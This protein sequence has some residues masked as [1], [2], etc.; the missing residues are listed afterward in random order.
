MYTEKDLA[1]IS[2]IIVSSGKHLKKKFNT[3]SSNKKK[4]KFVFKSKKELVIEEDNFSQDYIIKRLRKFD[5]QINIYSEELDNL[6]NL[7]NDKSN[8]KL[9]I[10]PLDGTHNF[11]FGIPN[12]AVSIALLDKNNIPIFGA[13]YLPMFDLLIR[14]KKINGIT[15]I[16]L[17]NKEIKSNLRDPTE[18]LEIITYDNQFY[19]LNSK[20]R[21]IYDK[22]TKAFFTT[23]ITGSAQYDAAFIAMGKI[24]GR[25]FNNTT[26]YD[27]SP[28]IP[29][30]L[31]AGGNVSDF[32]NKKI[33]ALSKKVILSSGNKIHKRLVSITKKFD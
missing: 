31:G 33:D 7:K 20:A 3:L 6:V 11:Y 1:I 27:L 14:N 23:R 28:C 5:N 8:Y 2:N 9:I 13:I 15:K 21:K 22:I 16:F 32:K 12:W 4:Q 24:H 26:S 19:K 18:F 25:V 10:D 29:I 30:I 17:K